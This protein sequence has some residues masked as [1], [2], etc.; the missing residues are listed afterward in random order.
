MGKYLV[1]ILT[2]PSQTSD[3]R[4]MTEPG[5][6]PGLERPGYARFN[7]SKSDYKQI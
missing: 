7:R 6:G 5:L 4:R 2:A 1:T 3:G